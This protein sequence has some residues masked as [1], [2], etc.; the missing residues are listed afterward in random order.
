MLP[1][2]RCTMRVVPGQRPHAAHL[3]SVRPPHARH[4]TRRLMVVCARVGRWTLDGVG[5]GRVGS[6]PL[7]G[8]GGC[9]ES[10]TVLH[11]TRVSSL[12]LDPADPPTRLDVVDALTV[13]LSGSATRSIR[14]RGVIARSGGSSTHARA[15]TSL[16]L[17][18][19]SSVTASSI[20]RRAAVAAVVVVVVRDPR[21]SA[22]SRD[23]ANAM[24][25][26]MR[27]W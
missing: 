13:T 8:L 11:A 1:I 3:P 12:D 27:Q 20:C 24:G 16:P 22:A 17:Y 25:G 18:M 14:E 26:E 9:V 15:S 21:G 6:G 19:S 4:T 10:D 23:G 2:W 7:G 5:S